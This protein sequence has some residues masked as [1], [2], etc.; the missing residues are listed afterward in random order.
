MENKK[1]L[2]GLCVGLV[3]VAAVLLGVADVLEGSGEWFKACLLLSGF[4]LGLWVFFIMLLFDRLDKEREAEFSE[5][6]EKEVQRVMTKD[7][8]RVVKDYVSNLEKR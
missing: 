5:K 2:V 4:F 8:K 1:L 6:V 3:I 7:L